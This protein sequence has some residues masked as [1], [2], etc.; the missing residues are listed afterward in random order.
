M[1]FLKKA[2]YV[3]YYMPPCTVYVLANEM[4]LNKVFKNKH[5]QNPKNNADVE[6]VRAFLLTSSIRAR[7]DAVL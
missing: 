6:R 3:V 1:S 7:T 2:L 5:M 4:F